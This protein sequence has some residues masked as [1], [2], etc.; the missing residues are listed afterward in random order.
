MTFRL[1]QLFRKATVCIKLILC[2]RFF[3][4]SGLVV[5]GSKAPIDFRVVSLLSACEFS[6][7]HWVFIIYFCMEM[8]SILEAN[9][10]HGHGVPL[11]AILSCKL[12]GIYLRIRFCYIVHPLAIRPLDCITTSHHNIRYLVSDVLPSLDTGDDC[13]FYPF[14]W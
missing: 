10:S 11:R 8:A 7:F 6:G 14:F 5:V 2:E 1:S 4:F 3:R 13:R 12:I 9:S